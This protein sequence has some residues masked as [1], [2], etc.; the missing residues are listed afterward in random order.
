MVREAARQRG[1]SAMDSWADD[2]EEIERRIRSQAA[3]SRTALNAK[4]TAV[5]TKAAEFNLRQWQKITKASMGVDIF[6][7]EP[8]L[9][10]ELRSWALENVKHSE[11][12]QERAVTDLFSR[13]QRGIREGTRHEDIGAQISKKFGIERRKADLLARDQVATLNAG[14]TEQRQTDL[15]ISEYIWR[16]SLDERVRGNPSGEYP[17]ARPSHHVMEGKICRWDDPTVY[18][19]GPRGEWRSRASIGGVQEHPSHPI[20]CRC[21]AEPRLDQLLERI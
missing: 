17:D 11:T 3:A 2:M 14:L 16:T 19:D 8:W 9:R 12:I 7:T 6:T 4:I 18:R 13:T 10:D 5:A 20:L 15:G 1:D 21:S